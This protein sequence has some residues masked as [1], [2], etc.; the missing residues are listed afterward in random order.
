MSKTTETG[1]RRT[2]EQREAH[3]AIRERSRHERPGPDE[4]IERGDLDELV[5]QGQF[6]ELAKLVNQIKRERR[7]RG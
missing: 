6:M 2:P 5:P 7:A 3:K 1:V 4:L